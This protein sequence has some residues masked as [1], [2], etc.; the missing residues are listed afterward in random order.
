[1]KIIVIAT[2]N[3]KKL[4][5]L[6]RYLKG[7]RAHVVSLKDFARVPRIVENG[8][9]FKTNAVKKALVI[10]R[11][12]QGLVLADDSGLV[13]AA[14]GGRPGVR[15]SRFAGPRKS[16]KQNNLKLLRLLEKVPPS[17]RQAK[18]V[19]AVAICDNGKIVKM[20]EESC[21]GIVAFSEKGGYGFGYDPLFL[22][23]KY[24]ETFGELGLKV[25]D[26]MSHRSK[27][28]KKA[29]EFLRS[30]FATAVK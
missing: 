7:V 20:I 11:F 8:T 12:T 18:F 15:S 16:D 3:E 9:T 30:Y 28:L 21:S 29:R 5:E 10:S 19:C 22:I 24:K 17:K 1:M 14:L 4:H 27:A 13:V 26:R 6:R 25:K 2:K 23:P